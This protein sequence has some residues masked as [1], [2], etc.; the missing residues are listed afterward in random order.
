MGKEKKQSLDSKA[1]KLCMIEFK[2]DFLSLFSYLMDK[3]VPNFCMRMP[4][5]MEEKHY[6]SVTT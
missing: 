2:G 4:I 5:I 6:T 3:F 1:I